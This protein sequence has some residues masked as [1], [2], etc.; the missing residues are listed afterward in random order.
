MQNGA[1]K[2][3]VNFESLRSDPRFYEDCQ[4]PKDRVESKVTGIMLN[5]A[6]S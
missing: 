1:P 3:D 5:G 6:I 4:Y 2:A